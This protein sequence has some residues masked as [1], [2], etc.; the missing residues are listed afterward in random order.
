MPAMGYAR[1]QGRVGDKSEQ[2]GGGAGSPNLLG[3]AAEC[4]S[5]HVQEAVHSRLE[6]KALLGAAQTRGKGGFD[7]MSG[8]LGEAR[9]RRLLQQETLLPHRLRKAFLL[10]CTSSSSTEISS[11]RSSAK[12]AWPQAAPTACRRSRGKLEARQVC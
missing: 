4:A 10:V 5:S 1:L 9:P 6:R 12:A 8:G 7:D 11:W 2:G 3:H